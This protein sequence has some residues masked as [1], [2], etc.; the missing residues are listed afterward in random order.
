MQT[1]SCVGIEI[2]SD[3][4]GGALRESHNLFMPLLLLSKT[5]AKKL[6]PSSAVV[7]IQRGKIDEVLTAGSQTRKY[8]EKKNVNYC[9]LIFSFCRRQLGEQL[10][11]LFS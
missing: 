10:V 5:E 8:K 2:G 7:K 11:P 9:C 3:T 1:H 6:L 4:N